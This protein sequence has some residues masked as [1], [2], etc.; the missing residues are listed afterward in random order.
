MDLAA[1]ARELLEA[2]YLRRDLDGRIVE[3]F[4]QLCERVATAIAKAEWSYG[5]AE[6][7]NRWAARF[8]DAIVNR[9]VMPNSPTL[10]NAGTPGGQLFAC[11]VNPLEDSM[12]SICHALTLQAL[13]QK[14]GGG[15][16]FDFSPL[17]PKFDLVQSTR[18]VASGPV[19]FLRLFD[20]MTAAIKQGGR[21]RGRTWAFCGWTTRKS[22]RSRT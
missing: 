14:S 15:T 20:A 1:N 3:T 5:Q 6:A 18:G 10:M 13:I 4:P 12:A 8:F 2:R 21:R 11:F 19:S 7:V 22:E 17:R 16:G 9:D